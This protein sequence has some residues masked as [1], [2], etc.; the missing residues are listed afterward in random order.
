MKLTTEEFK[1]LSI[2]KHGN[3]YNYSN[4]NYVGNKNN[5]KIICPIHGEFLQR[6]DHH[7]LGS[8]CKKC[9][10]IKS[11]KIRTK[12]IKIPKKIT[13]Y[14]NGI[15]KKG[16][17]GEGY[18][19]YCNSFFYNPNK[20]I[21][22]SRE[23]FNKY[24]IEIN[25]KNIQEKINKLG[26]KKCACGC[27]TVIKPFYRYGIKNIVFNNFI[28]G[29]N[30]DEKTLEKAHKNSKE[31]CSKRMKKYNDSLTKDQMKIK[32]KKTGIT[33][34]KMYKDGILTNWNKGKFGYK[35]KGGYKGHTPWNKGK[36]KKNNEIL[37]NLSKK[38]LGRIAWN[39]DK[40]KYNDERV[41]SYGLKRRGRTKETGD[42]CAIKASNRMKKNNPMKDMKVREKALYGWKM[43]PN[44]PEKKIILKQ[45]PNLIFTGDRSFWIT[46]KDC[47]FKNPDFIIKPF[48][49]NKKVIEVWGEY[50][51]RNE[52]P[53]EL[54]KKYKEV[55][56]DCL[57]IPYKLIVQ[58]K[59]DDLIKNFI[60]KGVIQNA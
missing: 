21:C 11:S 15:A 18:C 46:F 25:K 26:E 51:H 24:K 30:L 36:T 23:H 6:P 9:G 5:V 53:N 7:I 8:G 60:N 34:A 1:K 27:G 44:K 22:C 55:D 37:L 58:D 42:S 10:I 28:R 59:Y 33:L 50:W 17:K 19:A 20:R 41:K 47:T 45:Y 12:K 40:N 43:A 48:S 38:M 16:R 54:I 4:V 32:G 2:E 31:I 35:I 3:F 29:H 49:I 56:I 13:I 57:I 52:D 14:E 39:K